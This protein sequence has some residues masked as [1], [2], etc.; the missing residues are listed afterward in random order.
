M[1]F[2]WELER[3]REIDQ[4]TVNDDNEKDFDFCFAFELRCV[5]G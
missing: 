1:R 4:F 2:R 3:R 5:A